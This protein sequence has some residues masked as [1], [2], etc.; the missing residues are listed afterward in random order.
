MLASQEFMQEPGVLVDLAARACY[1]PAAPAPAGTR[2]RRVRTEAEVRKHVGRRRK[3]K[4]AKGAAV[5]QDA[6]APALAEPLAG[7][8]QAA[9]DAPT[10]ADELAPFQA[11]TGPSMRC[12][13]ALRCACCCDC[14]CLAVPEGVLC[15]QTATQE[16]SQSRTSGACSRAVGLCRPA[17]AR[18]DGSAIGRQVVR[19]KAKLRAFAFSPLPA[20][21]GRPALM[22]LALANNVL[23]VGAPP[24]RAPAHTRQAQHA[25]ATHARHSVA[26]GSAATASA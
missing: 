3:R 25:C 21:A 15:S 26:V 5:E 11:R 6:A 24:A 8:G 9:A 17:V 4:R 7:A 14:A 19:G 12:Q 1:T 22:A 13:R 2:V 20:Q 10:A 23:E 16:K 18:A